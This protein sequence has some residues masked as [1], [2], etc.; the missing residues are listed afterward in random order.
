M[1]RR[2]KRGGCLKVL[3][4]VLV[5]I[6]GLGVLLWSQNISWDNVEWKEVLSGKEAIP[7]SENTIA[8]ETLT[9]QYY[10][11]QL[12][13]EEKTVYKEILQGV[14]EQESEIYLHT[15]DAQCAGDIYQ[16]VLY[17]SPELFWC[18]GEAN[19][20]AF[21]TYAVFCP[22]YAYSKDG[23][24]AAQASIDQAVAVCMEGVDSNAAAYDKIKYAY[25]YIV[26]TTDYDAA[27]P[28]NQNICSVFVNK[29]SVCAGY[30]KAMQYLMRQW[31]IGCIYVTGLDMDGEAHAWNI[32]NCDGV[33]CHVDVTWGDPVFMAQEEETVQPSSNI[34]Y[35]YL[36]CTDEEISKTHTVDAE[37]VLPECHSMDYNYYILNGQYYDYV[38]EE[39]IMGAM[40]NT[41][42][43]GGEQTAFK[44]ANDNLYQ[45]AHDLILNNLVGRALQNLMS[46]Y[47]LNQATYLY[48]DDDVTN[49]IIIIWNYQ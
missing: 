43:E 3:T 35:D 5:V 42:Y 40:N 36:C 10:Y 1:G 38:D 45:Q 41:I 14:Q 37:L 26:N 24:A 12:Q 21:E 4:F 33:Y 30:S 13:E 22:V 20:T 23:R 7:F 2:R 28:D 31:G 29:A 48:M 18:S 44:F 6:T 47:G 16:M 39:E 9:N 34:N 27:A 8:E 17:D 49:K 11:N 46:N 32:V 19:T 15:S 25:E